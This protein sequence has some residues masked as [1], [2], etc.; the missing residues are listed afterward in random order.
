MLWQA[1]WVPSIEADPDSVWP[2]VGQRVR[3]LSLDSETQCTTMEPPPMA[4]GRTAAQCGV[5]IPE[6]QTASAF[7]IHVISLN[8]HAKNLKMLPIYFCQ[9][10]PRD[11]IPQPVVTAGSLA[12]G[13]D[14]V[15][16]C[17]VPASRPS[18]NS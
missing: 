13:L 16:S 2:A 15:P 11:T 7:H 18:L 17:S 4:P 14:T 3:G 10:F 12:A 1:I 5:H 6:G 8:E 9:S